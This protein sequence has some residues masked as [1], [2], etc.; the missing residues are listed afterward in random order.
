MK[1]TKKVPYWYRAKPKI[2]GNFIFSSVMV[3]GGLFLIFAGTM[4]IVEESDLKK[5]GV[6]S[7]VQIIPG[8]ERKECDRKPWIVK[9]QYKI[10]DKN[11]ATLEWSCS[12]EVS[13]APQTAEVRYLASQPE[14]YMK[15]GE[16]SIL[17]YA[18]IIF[19]ASF[20]GIL[21]ALNFYSVLLLNPKSKLARPKAKSLQWLWTP[22]EEQ[23]SITLK[24]YAL[25]L[26]PVTIASA[27]LTLGIVLLF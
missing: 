25:L 2:I 3:L 1:K 19:F 13:S 4:G 22:L 26:G 12:D 20:F 5:N 11:A 18:A 15:E 9:A 21:S 27:A 24:Q 8:T 6:V 10:T 23:P 17:I 16:E 14:I 7:T